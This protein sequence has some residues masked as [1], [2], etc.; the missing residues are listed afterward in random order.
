LQNIH[1][2]LAQL[3]PSKEQK[4][5]KR[6]H[7]SGVQDFGNW[8]KV[9][10]GI[11]EK[12]FPPQ[13]SDFSDNELERDNQVLLSKLSN[14]EIVCEEI[15]DTEYSHVYYQKCYE[16]LR[17]RGKSKQEIFEMRRFAWQTA[18][19]FN[20]PMMLYDWVSLDESDIFKAIKL[21]YDY[22]QISQEQ[23]IEFENFVRLHAS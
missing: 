8:K 3:F 9:C 14:W 13:S 20:F 21:L 17:K 2:F 11:L 5:P 22:K 23:Q 16:E 10:E 6:S 15:V 4:V 7:L 1:S 18:G 19:W 12:P